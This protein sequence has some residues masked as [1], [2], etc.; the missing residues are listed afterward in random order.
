MELVGDILN[1]FLAHPEAADTAE[2]IVR[3]R[4]LEATVH[5]RLDQTRHALAFLVARGFLRT[6]HAARSAP[7]FALVPDRRSAAEGFLSGRP[8]GERPDQD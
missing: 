6:H 2:G 1:Y 3:W 5:R 8:S 4:L 7:I